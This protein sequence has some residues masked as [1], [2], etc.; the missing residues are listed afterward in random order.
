M[1][2]VN[3]LIFFNAVIIYTL[4]MVV[5]FRD[6]SAEVGFQLVNEKFVILSDLK[7]G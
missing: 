4:R 1:I 7:W 3:K 6:K 2:A 5:E